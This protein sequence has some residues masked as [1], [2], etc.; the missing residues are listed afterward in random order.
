MSSSH[1]IKADSFKVSTDGQ[2][3]DLEISKGSESILKGSW[4]VDGSLKVE[5]GSDPKSP[6]TISYLAE[7]LVQFQKDCSEFWVPREE[8][9]ETSNETVKENTARIEEIEKKLKDI[10]AREEIETA[11]A[12]FYNKGEID[13]FLSQVVHKTGDEYVQGN[14]TFLNNVVVANTEGTASLTVLP[15]GSKTNLGADAYGLHVSAKGGLQLFGTH[16]LNGDLWSDEK[17]AGTGQSVKIV[18]DS[19]S[20]TSTDKAAIGFDY[21]NEVI[22]RTMPNNGCE[23]VFCF[24][25]WQWSSDAH[26]EKE[27]FAGVR[28]VKLNQKSA[29]SGYDI[30]N[31]SEGD[32][33]WGGG[34]NSG[35]S[36]GGSAFGDEI[37]IGT[38]SSATG[39]N[40]IAI[41]KCA[42]S[43]EACSIAIGMDSLAGEDASVA[44]GDCSGAYGEGA[45][46]IG[47]VSNA[48]C[49]GSVAIGYKSNASR[50]ESVVIGLRSRSYSFDT[51]SIG[52]DSCINTSSE[53]SISIG[54][55]SSVDGYYS[56][57]VGHSAFA[58]SYSVAVGAGAK[59]SGGIS[60]AI[61]NGSCSNGYCSLAMGSFS[62]A[63][64]TRSVA[65]GNIARS[66]NHE[67]IA[68]GGESLS[69]CEGGIAIGSCS[70]SSVYQSL[71]IGTGSVSQGDSSIAV[72]YQARA[73]GHSTVA[74]G[75]N[76]VV[77]SPGSGTVL[78]CANG[79]V[80]SLP[81][82]TT[83]S[84]DNLSGATHLRLVLVAGQALDSGLVENSY[85]I[86]QHEDHLNAKAEG[87][88]ISAKN[89]FS[90]L[91]QF[92][93][94]DYNY[95]SEEESGGSCSYGSSMYGESY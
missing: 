85:I 25:A 64:G 58:N 54:S 4:K 13:L 34:C 37:A 55:S 38:G 21:A 26:T 69:E 1:T 46:A 67:A 3:N 75:S 7:S 93:A 48:A 29:I 89:F 87:V 28:L 51:I 61:G 82:S 36:G 35:G 47:S 72:G 15:L 11:L 50:E 60:V 90:M 52:H 8:W 49:V 43:L 12:N 33:R 16:F 41:G 9:E 10:S 77:K 70:R 20:L 73:L 32:A 66:F 5:Q 45:V 86:F 78:V 84:A 30:L 24:E 18:R 27:P 68:I 71:A 53:N 44:I 2:T 59:S 91:K 94:E 23:A 40:S 92:G 57:V 80:A 22:F 31:V 39:C 95:T 19:V 83:I 14:K 63:N 76:S 88:K 6:V 74:I 65:V 42:S 17:E 56:T 79:A 62:R 81:S